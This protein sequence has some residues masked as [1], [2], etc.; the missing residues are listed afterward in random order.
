MKRRRLT[1][2][3]RVRIF[4]RAHGLCHLCGFRIQVGQPWECS[5]IVSL[6][7]GGTDDESN[8][9]PAHKKHCHRTKTDEEA[10]DR[11]K[12]VRIRA[13]HLGIKNE[14]GPKLPAG[15]ES[16]WRKTVAGKVVERFTQIELH[17]ATMRRRQIGGE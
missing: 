8:M 10:S 3:A 14:N 12:E 2:L 1:K 6:W 17:R 5:H 15:R 13:R 9:A 4:D 7:A 11:S 16:N